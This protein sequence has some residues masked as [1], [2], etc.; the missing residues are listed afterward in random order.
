MIEDAEDATEVVVEDGRALK[1]DTVVAKEPFLVSPPT[2]VSVLYVSV[3]SVL[4]VSSSVDG[5]PPLPTFL[6]PYSL[7]NNGVSRLNSVIIDDVRP[8]RPNRVIRTVGERR[9]LED[10]PREVVV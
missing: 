2:T 8:R 9:R 5:P 1:E 7:F 6:F 10:G 4:S 3:A